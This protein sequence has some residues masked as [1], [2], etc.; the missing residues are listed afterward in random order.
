MSGSNNNKNAGPTAEGK[1]PSP[2]IEGTAT[3]VSVEAG[4]ADAKEDKDVVGTADDAQP[5][6]EAAP[7]DDAAENDHPEEDYEEDDHAEDDDEG[8]GH[9]DE[10]GEPPHDVPSES[11]AAGAAAATARQSSGRGFLG[12]IAALITHA[13]AGIAGRHC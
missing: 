1:R 8:D 11:P 4:D 7:E 13:F 5:G 10:I 2:T 3:E 9:L 12:W 6:K